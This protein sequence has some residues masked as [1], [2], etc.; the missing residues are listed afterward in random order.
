MIKDFNTRRN[1]TEYI[2]TCTV[3]F[4]IISE[5]SIQYNEVMFMPCVYIMYVRIHFKFFILFTI[6]NNVSKSSFAREAY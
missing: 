5:V 1:S 2:D 3:S 4:L 6:N